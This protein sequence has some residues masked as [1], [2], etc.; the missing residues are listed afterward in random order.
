M[1]IA[2]THFYTSFV[3]NINYPCVLTIYVQLAFSTIFV[4]FSTS[5]LNISLSQTCF[6]NLR[7]CFLSYHS[8]S[9]PSWFG[10]CKGIINRCMKCEIKFTNIVLCVKQTAWFMCVHYVHIMILNI[11]TDFTAT[12]AHTGIW[13]TK[14]INWFTVPNSILIPNP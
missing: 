10:L 13:D 4:I 12:I 1:L 2:L 14:Y 6:L 9:L 8:P 3:W 11:W 5:F 7:N